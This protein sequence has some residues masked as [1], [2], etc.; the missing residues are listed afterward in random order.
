MYCA[1]FPMPV[2][3]VGGFT[4]NN[5][6]IDGCSRPPYNCTGVR[7]CHAFNAYYKNNL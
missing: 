4:V 2:K 3:R 6:H 7:A 1:V 5:D